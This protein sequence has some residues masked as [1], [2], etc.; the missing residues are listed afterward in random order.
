MFLAFTLDI[1]HLREAL[2]ICIQILFIERAIL[3][4]DQENQ[5]GRY[6]FYLQKKKTK[7]HLDNMFGFISIFYNMQTSLFSL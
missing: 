5:N 2:K 3:S 4:C 1:Y 6:S 7:D